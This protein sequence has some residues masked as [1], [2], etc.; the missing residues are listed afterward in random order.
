MSEI[1]VNNLKDEG[2]T[3]APILTYGCEVPVG[4][5]ITGDGGINIAGVLTCASYTG[6]VTGNASGT[7]GG[8]SG[9][10]NITINNL[11]GVAATFSGVVTYEDVTN[12]DSIGI[13]TARSYVSIADS[14]VHTGDIDTAI[15]F[16]SADTITAETG[17]SERLRVDSSGRLLV[18]TT[19]NDSFF[20]SGVQIVGVSGNAPSALISRFSND[21]TAPSLWFHKSRAASVGSNTIVN[22]GDDIGIIQFWGADGSS[23]KEA[24]RI[25]GEIGGTPGSND[26]P[27]R[28][29][30]HT[31]ADGAAS[32]TER[33]RIDS[34]GRV[35]TAGASGYNHSFY[36]VDNSNGLGAFCVENGDT[37]WD[38]AAAMS[39]AKG[40]NGTSTSNCLVKF[41][42]N[43]WG[44]GSGK[45]TCNGASQ[46]AFGTYSDVRLKENIIDLPSQLENIKNLRPVEFDFIAGGHQIGFIAQEFENVYPDAVGS[47]PSEE[48]PEEERLTIT[49]W[50]KTEAY[51]VKALQEAIAK[52]ETLE[53]KVA[54]LEAA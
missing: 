40:Y 48:N 31:T 7:A 4:M 3:G 28:L 9:S 51:L 20:N 17:G 35:T 26:M 19:T 23:T 10:P 34:Q 38:G 41:F 42:M 50:S 30:F 22:N 15:R 11:V 13:I 16:P 21:A 44:N 46:A 2:G 54:A 43:G 37:T 12:V 27:G 5:G 47:A 29:T 1:R 6:D 49:G 45:I 36:A 24:A 32:P 52:I 53:T 25:T 8:L 14:I 18:G 33:L 39:I